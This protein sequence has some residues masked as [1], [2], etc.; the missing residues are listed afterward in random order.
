M[1]RRTLLTSVAAVAM[2]ASFS[3]PAR[4]GKAPIYTGLLSNAA[5]GGY[6]TVAY[7]T[8]GMPVKGKS[9]FRTKWMGADW[10]FASKEHLEMFKANPTAYAPQYGGYC[11]YGVSQMAA[12]KGDPLL[13]KIVD[14]KLYLNINKAVVKI[15]NKDIPGYISKADQNWP[16]VLE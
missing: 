15:W 7:F 16:K 14:G 3:L 12:V 2:S 4:A 5:V 8:D 9:Q 1:N 6:D 10:Y 11:A 13:W